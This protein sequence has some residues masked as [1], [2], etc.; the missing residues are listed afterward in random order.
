MKRFR[1]AISVQSLTDEEIDPVSLPPVL[2]MGSVSD[3]IGKLFLR[4]AT[5]DRLMDSVAE[6]PGL[7]RT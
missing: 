5:R 1:A 2:L 6:M 3:V 7:T 4:E